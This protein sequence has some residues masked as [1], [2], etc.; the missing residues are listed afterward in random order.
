MRISEVLPSLDLHMDYK[1]MNE[2]EFDVLMLCESK[3]DAL[4]CIFI[5]SEKYICS[6]PGNVTMIITT[7]SLANL[8]RKENRGILAIDEPRVFFFCLH[9]YLA[10]RDGYMRGIFPSCIAESARISEKTEISDVN[11]VIGE[12]VIIESFV[13]IYSNVKIGDNSI[14]RAGAVIGGSGFEFK[15][16]AG[17]I[18]KVEHAGGVKIGNH[19]EIQNNTCID[20]AIYPWDDTTIGDNS[21]ID[22]LVYIAHGV[23]VDRNVLIVAN[24]GIGGRTEISEESWVGL[25]ATIRNGINIGKGARANMGAVVT[26]NI[27]EHQAVTGNFAINHK[28]FIENM[29]GGVNNYIIQILYWRYALSLHGERVMQ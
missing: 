11:V 24:A 16:Y 9:N 18:L 27:D 25:G 17:G 4:A 26:K 12:N 21:K 29:R 14:I 3:C 8:L 10:K 20:R 2:Q 19:V 1:L 5:D 7:F 15:R 13:T 28:E 6:I 22:N 23:K